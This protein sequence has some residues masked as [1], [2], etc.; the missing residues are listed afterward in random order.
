MQCLHIRRTAWPGDVCHHMPNGCRSRSGSKE[1]WSHKMKAYGWR[2]PG[3]R[4][5][6]V[7]PRK[8]WRWPK[9]VGEARQS[10]WRGQPMTDGDGRCGAWQ[11][12]ARVCAL[13]RFLFCA[14]CPWVYDA[15]PPPAPAYLSRRQAVARGAGPA[16]EPDAADGLQRGKEGVP[17]MAGKERRE[18]R[19]LHPA[20]VAEAGDLAAGRG[21]MQRTKPSPDLVACYRKRANRRVLSREHTTRQD[22]TRTDRESRML[23]D[24]FNTLTFL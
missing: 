19:A 21:A 15:R 16:E 8:P 9:R 6:P 1:S 14:L 24:V 7:A 23:M 3:A 10:R 11:A 13:D 22:R 2:R 20:W 18:S 5:S 17:G 12:A 4:R